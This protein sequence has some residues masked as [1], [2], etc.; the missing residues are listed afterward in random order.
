M[1]ELSIKR[2]LT[3]AI[4]LTGGLALL[5]AYS[6]SVALEVT[7]LRAQPAR[8]AAIGLGVLGACFGL[9]LLFSARLQ[10]RL[11]QM[12]SSTLDRDEQLLA[13]RETLEER[14]EQETAAREKA[15]KTARR[16]ADFDPL[17][18]LPNRVL[19]NDRLSQALA[20]AHR[21]R[22][23]PL[24]LVLNLDRFKTIND[25]LG[26]AIGD[27]VLQGVAV[28]LTA[29][30]RAEDTVARLGDEF[31]VMLPSHDGPGDA[32]TVAE[33]L[34]QALNAPFSIGGHELYVGASIGISLFPEDG[35]DRGRA[36]QERRRSA[37]P[38]QGAGARQLP[39]LRPGHECRGPG[40]VRARGRSAPAPSS[41]RSSCS[42]ISPSWIRAAA[43]S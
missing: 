13:E 21:R 14:L 43:R 3:I 11:D 18:G 34:R 2:K 1:R 40:P 31:Q 37:P 25:T 12:L 28:R 16:L 33:K 23:K 19:F 30:L 42:T 22:L 35:E 8:G 4:T 24:V 17:T 38:R 27:Q 39:A 6:G 29:A 10:R 9:G 36:D 20:R 7:S 26:K 5:L 41:A 15:E 32:I